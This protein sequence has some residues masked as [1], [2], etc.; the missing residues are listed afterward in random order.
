MESKCQSEPQTQLHHTVLEVTLSFWEAH[1]FFLLI[2]NIAHGRKKSF[3][4]NINYIW[5]YAG[6]I[7]LRYMG[8]AKEKN[9]EVATF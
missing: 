7:M 8:A 1:Y 5:K 4:G 3:Q 9:E 2:L 6:I